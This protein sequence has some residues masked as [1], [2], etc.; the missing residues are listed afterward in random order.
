MELADRSRDERK[1]KGADP[2]L[3]ADH[4]SVLLEKSWCSH[5]VSVLSLALVVTY[6]LRCAESLTSEL[7]CDTSLAALDPAA[8]LSMQHVSM[9]D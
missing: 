2:A 1:L 7:S 3:P 6:Q 9:T 5:P 4:Q 8:V